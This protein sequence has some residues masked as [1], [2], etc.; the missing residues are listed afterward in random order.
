MRRKNIKEAVKEYFFIN[1][2]SK[3]RVRQLEKEL[4]LPLPSVIRYA[5]ELKNEGILT[6][7]KVGNVVFYAAD[8]T[9][10]NYLIGKK[11][12]NMKQV[13]LSGLVDYLRE[14]LSNPT[15]VL[16]GSY[17]KGEDTEASDIDLY[18]ETPSK[19]EV[20]LTRFEKVLKRKIQAFKYK[21]IRG[22]ANPH[23][24]NNI[25]NGIVLNGFVEVFK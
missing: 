18:I 6:T 9:S 3:M 7:V 4:K 22:I 5:K 2:T 11:L 25:L 1:P 23:L 19:K 20:D 14:E 15:I 21:N 12:F 24:S 16:F 17:A 10:K 13:Y 8:K